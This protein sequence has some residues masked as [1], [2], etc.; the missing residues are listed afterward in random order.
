M[1]DSIL[2]KVCDV[3]TAA[4]S[5]SSS[6]DV[7]ESTSTLRMVLYDAAPSTASQLSVMELWV[8]LDVVRPVGCATN[9]SCVMVILKV[10]ET[11][12]LDASLTVRVTL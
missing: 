5:T 12:V 2:L 7:P 8:M 6:S 11:D 1:L 9:G 3:A 4:A 10:C